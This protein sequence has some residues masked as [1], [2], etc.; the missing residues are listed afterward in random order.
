MGFSSTRAQLLTVPPFACSA[1][2][3]IASSFLSD[4]LR[5]RGVLF[6]YLVAFAITGFSIL[7]GLRGTGVRYFAVFLATCGAFTAAPILLAWAVDNAAGPSV[8]A[9]VSGYVVGAGNIGALIATWTYLPESAPL[10]LEG[11]YVNL[12]GSILMGFLVATAT[13]NLW[14]ENRF[15]RAGGRAE[16]LEQPQEIVQRLGHLHP[17]YRYTL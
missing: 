5:K 6:I 7:V 2:C 12:G 13:W 15:R 17:E 4:R 9:V 16:G 14:K 8:R 1:L 11:H 3:C 10:Y